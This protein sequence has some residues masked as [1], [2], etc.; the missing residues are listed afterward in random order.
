MKKCVEVVYNKLFEKYPVLVE[1]KN[2]IMAAF[3]VLDNCFSQGGKVL[4]CGNGGSA[5]DSEHIIGELMKGFLLKREL[6]EDTL[7]KFKMAL[8]DNWEYI[9]ASLQGALPAISLVS[10]TGISTAVSNDI[11]G[12]MI[13]A[14]Q[15]FGYARKG[16]VLIG[17][18]TSGNAKDVVNAVNVAKVMEMKTIGLTGVGGGV[19]GK[20]CDVTIKVPDKETYI[21][22]EYHLPVYH[23]LCAMLEMQYFG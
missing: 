12:D 16:D 7:D 3:D 19:M 14:Q 10:Q 15:V 13:F 6:R 1:C 2:D 18:S 17:I 20:I 22:Q 9:T 4:V 23:T 11:A 5:C 8:P 21:I